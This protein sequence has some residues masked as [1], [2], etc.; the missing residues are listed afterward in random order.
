MKKM[1]LSITI[2]TV[3][4]STTLTFI[5]Q[6]KGDGWARFTL[7]FKFY[8]PAR[9]SRDVH[10]QVVSG[11]ESKDSLFHGIFLSR[12]EYYGYLSSIFPLLCCS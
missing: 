1:T 3:L 9:G 4:C 8:V 11:I 10:F 7:P 2:A 5:T 6:V 12:I